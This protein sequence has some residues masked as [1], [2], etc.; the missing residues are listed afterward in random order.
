MNKSIE[1]RLTRLYNEFDATGRVDE[2]RH[3][4]AIKSKSQG[5]CIYGF[6]KNEADFMEILYNTKKR[7]RAKYALVVEHGPEL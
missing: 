7:W 1:K 2:K 3:A 5:F 4:F 6:Y